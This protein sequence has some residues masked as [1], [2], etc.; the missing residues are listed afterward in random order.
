[1]MP[2]LCLLFVHLTFVVEVHEEIIL[3]EENTEQK[4]WMKLD[5][6]PACNDMIYAAAECVPNGR[7]QR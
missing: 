4:A 6:C 7:Y 3:C 1:M 5:H 2:F